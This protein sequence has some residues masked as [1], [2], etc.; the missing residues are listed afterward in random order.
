MLFNSY[1]YLLLFL[2]LVLTVHLSLKRWA[3][4]EVVGR[5]WLVVASLFFYGY[6]GPHYSLLLV[7]SLLFNFALGTV[8]GRDRSRGVVVRRALLGCGVTVNIVVLGYFKYTAFIFDNINL[9]FH[10]SISST[11][12]PLPPGLSFITFI[13]LAYLVERYRSPEHDYSAADYSVFGTFFPY[14][15][16]G[17]IVRVSDIVPQFKN[18]LSRVDYRG[19]SSGLFLFCIGLFKK[20]TIADQFGQFAVEGFDG[21][22]QLNFMFAWATSL[23]YTFQIYFD[24]S[25]YSDMAIGTA[26]M[27]GCKLPFNFD[28]PYK[29]LDIQD[30]WRRWHMTLGSFLRD[31]IYIPLG[32]NRSGETRTHI[33]LMATFLLCGIW[34]GAGWNFIFWGAL[35]GAGL[36][37]RRLWGRTG[38]ALSAVVAWLV[39]FNFVNT[40]WV[41]FRA[42]T[43]AQAIDMVK[44]MFGFNGVTLP[45]GA[46]HLLGFLGPSV[47]FMDWRQIMH[48][49][50]DAWIWIPI[51]LVVCLFFHNSNRMVEDF[52]P[53]W[54]GYLVAAAGAYAIVHLFR[55]NE[56]LYFNF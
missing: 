52:R 37:V 19:L 36:I 34:H 6:A 49:S 55:M 48:R 39:T 50:R 4:H 31:Y 43:W 5:V 32:G 12:P 27:F 20:V 44:T 7:G 29:A 2:P 33:N 13:Q 28:S 18:T 53:D 54:K 30:F 8:L 38:L 11:P 1:E 45:E 26:L 10:V 21:A 56:F 51:A 22:S 14:L 17:P 24:F 15:L 9:F 23:S 46:R 40:A 3:R 16:S 47:Q 25:G 35:H 42:R 41:F